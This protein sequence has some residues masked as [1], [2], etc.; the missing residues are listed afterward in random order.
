ME[1]QITP[2]NETME[3]IQNLN[4]DDSTRDDLIELY[5]TNEELGKLIIKLI[6]YME[7]RMTDEDR[8]PITD[9]LITY[10][11]TVDS[12]A[13]KYIAKTASLRY[14]AEMT[15]GGMMFPQN[16]IVIEME[17]MFFKS[18]FI[19]CLLDNGK[20]MLIVEE[21]KIFSIS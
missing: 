9:I 16:V 12:S 14:S 4:I 18:Y 19:G 5:C 20:A 2:S 17:S 6:H 21:S 10:G 8:Y 13:L 7:G 15:I 3:V 11:V 1:A